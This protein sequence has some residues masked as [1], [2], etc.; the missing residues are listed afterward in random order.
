MPAMHAREEIISASSSHSLPLSLSCFLFISF[1]SCLSFYFLS[2]PLLP[3]PPFFPLSVSPSFSLTPFLWLAVSLGLCTF[4]AGK[5]G[6][7]SKHQ[8]PRS[9]QRNPSWLSP[10]CRPP[11]LPSP[12]FAFDNFSHIWAC[13]TPPL[14]ASF[15]SVKITSILFCVFKSISK[16]W[17]HADLIWKVHLNSSEFNLCSTLSRHTFLHPSTARAVWR[18]TDGSCIYA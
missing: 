18:K 11:S 1:F 5:S 12:N 14:A 8:P 13:W 6:A 17:S 9:A 4:Q 3:F 2:L 16:M 15:L 7:L 10:R